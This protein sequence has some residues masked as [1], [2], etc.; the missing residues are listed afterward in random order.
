MNLLL[1][2]SVA[3]DLTFGKPFT[4]CVKRLS[5]VVCRKKVGVHSLI[6]TK[7]DLDRL[8]RYRILRSSRVNLISHN[9]FQ[10]PRSTTSS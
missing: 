4:S 3:L 2:L 8:S 9:T 1:H 7:C 10:A 6:E 5:V